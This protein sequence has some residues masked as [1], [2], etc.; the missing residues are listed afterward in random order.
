LSSNFLHRSLV[1]KKQI[2]LF[3]LI[4]I[5]V[6]Y[7]VVIKRRDYLDVNVLELRQTGD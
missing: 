2:R 5:A 4:F 3:V 6:L 7:N 1:A